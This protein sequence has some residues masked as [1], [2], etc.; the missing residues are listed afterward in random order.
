MLCWRPSASGTSRGNRP[1]GMSH[2]RATANHFYPVVD[3]IGQLVRRAAAAQATFA[4]LG[5]PGPGTARS[6][7]GKNRSLAFTVNGKVWRGSYATK[8]RPMSSPRPYLHPVS[9]LAGTTVTI[10]C[11]RIT[12]GTSARA[13]PS[14]T[15]TASISGAGALHADAGAYV[16]RKYD[17]R[18]VTLAVDASGGRR[19]GGS[20][21]AA[22]AQTRRRRQH[23][24]TL[25]NRARGWFSP[26]QRTAEV[27]LG[28]RR[29][30][31]LAADARL[32]A[33]PGRSLIRSP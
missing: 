5:A 29:L 33:H 32:R 30:L 14:R 28:R 26:P 10:I 15:W 19:R 16:W 21:V 4:E 12:C 2:G 7:S 9:T 20:A 18:I 22:E 27:E 25:A 3:G 1:R 23:R 6:A 17:G 8:I 24:A 31:Q 13:L 11:P